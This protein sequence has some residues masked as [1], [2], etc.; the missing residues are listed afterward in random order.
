MLARRAVLLTQ[1]DRYPCILRGSSNVQGHA[2]SKSHGIIPFADPYPLTPFESYR[3]K[4]RVGGT[5]G[6]HYRTGL[7]TPLESV[8]P[9]R[10]PFHTR[11]SHPE[12]FRITTFKSVDS[13]QLKVSF[14]IT[15]FEKPGRGRPVIL[16]RSVNQNTNKGYLPRATPNVRAAGAAQPLGRPVL[17][18]TDA[19]TLPHIYR[20]CAI[21]P[22]L[23][24][25][26]RPFL[27]PWRLS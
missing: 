24:L 14:R 1:L 15:T 12:P 11:I 23:R 2:A 5:Q 17:N 19:S 10:L 20:C 4:N 18:R 26:D 8:L 21:L 6:S 13:E 9:R 16:T 22:F 7:L 25:G 27:P 3:F